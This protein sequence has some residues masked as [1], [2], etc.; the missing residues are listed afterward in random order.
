[1]SRQYCTRCERPLV[2]CICDCIRPIDNQVEICFLQHPSESKQAK[3]SVKLAH[4]CLNKSRIIVGENFTNND[5]LNQML[6]RPRQQ[7]YLLYPSESATVATPMA[8]KLQANTLLIVLDGTW[9]KAYKMLQLSKNVQALPRLTLDK[10]IKSQYVIRKHHKPTDV[11][12]LEACAHALAI[13]E[14]NQMRY[15]PLFDAF[16]QFNKQ[17]ILLQQQYQR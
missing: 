3:G 6:Q 14:H 16:A 12:S 11:S 1:M 7:A 8:A 2:T 4:L 9:K 17:Q 10:Q 15:Q 13:L 5:E